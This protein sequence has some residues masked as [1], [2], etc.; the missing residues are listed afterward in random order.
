[1]KAIICGGRDF[2]D[3]HYLYGVLNQCK[4]WWSLTHIISG[5]A[6]GADQ[7]AHEWAI[8]NQIKSTV[9]MADWDRLGKSAGFIRNMQMLDFDPDVVI[10]FKGGKGTEH[11]IRIAR[12]KTTPV[13]IV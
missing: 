5:G 10:A 8:Q 12:E 1:M 2:N 6:R 7:L 9:I 11:M 3:H 13:F 4:G